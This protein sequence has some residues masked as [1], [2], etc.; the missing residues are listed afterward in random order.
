MHLPISFWLAT[1]RS[2]PG[3]D[4]KPWDFVHC[5]GVHSLGSCWCL[6]GRGALNFCHHEGPR[7]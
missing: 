2:E 7:I 6:D 1:G 4:G 3:Q 5:K